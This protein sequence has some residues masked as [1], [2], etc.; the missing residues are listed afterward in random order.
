MEDAILRLVV[1]VA[2][3]S[4]RGAGVFYTSDSCGAFETRLIGPI[5][6]IGLIGPISPIPQTIP[7][8]SADW[9]VC[10]TARY[11]R[12]RVTGRI[13]SAERAEPT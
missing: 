11:D 13:Q 4:T 3:A 5:G 12:I 9:T 8:Y 6:L 1:Q 7:H 10:G 2:Y